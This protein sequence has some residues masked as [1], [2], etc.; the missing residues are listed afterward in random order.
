MVTTDIILQKPWVKPYISQAIVDDQL[1]A[2]GHPK[3]HEIFI[4]T[5]F[6]KLPN[7]LNA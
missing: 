2:L 3:N 6:A 7:P 1:I 4:D 5:K